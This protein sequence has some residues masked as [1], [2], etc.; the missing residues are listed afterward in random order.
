MLTLQVHLAR[1][2]T[3][4][5]Q[6]NIARLSFNAITHMLETDGSL[7]NE[8]RSRVTKGVAKGVTKSVALV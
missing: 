5:E 3:L 8:V 6:I 1:L 4:R 2:A 7:D